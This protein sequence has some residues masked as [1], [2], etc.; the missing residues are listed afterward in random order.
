MMSILSLH[1]FYLWHEIFSNTL[2]CFHRHITHVQDTVPGL[3]EGIALANADPVY[4]GSGALL[5]TDIILEP[6]L[7]RVNLSVSC[8]S[9]SIFKYLDIL[10][11]NIIDIS[12][13]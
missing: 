1:V 10:S 6:G 13:R 11:Y 4:P 5:Q 8:T 9:K 7:N 2:H 12:S 3:H